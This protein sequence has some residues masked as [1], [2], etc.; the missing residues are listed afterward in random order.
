MDRGPAVCACGDQVI[1]QATGRG[2]VGHASTTPARPWRPRWSPAGWR[3]PRAA[4]C[5]DGVGAGSIV[6]HVRTPPLVRERIGFLGPE[7]TFTEQAL[8]SQPDL[9]ARELVAM[10]SIPDVLLAVEP[11]DVDLGF[12]GIENSIEG[13]SRS[14]STRWPSRPTW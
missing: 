7:G 9:A 6:R 2:V 5:D 13:R 10:P 11:G 14:R 4:V 8:L 12:V 1:A 3:T